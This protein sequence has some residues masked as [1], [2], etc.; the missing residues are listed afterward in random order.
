MD[1]D[2][3]PDYLRDNW[4]SSASPWRS[5][6]PAR[7][8]A[9]A[10]SRRTVASS[11]SLTPLGDA[12]MYQMPLHY[13]YTLIPPAHGGPPPNTAVYDN[14]W[15]LVLTAVLPVRPPPPHAPDVQRRDHENPNAC[16]VI[17][18]VSYHGRHAIE[19]AEEEEQWELVCCASRPRHS[20][21]CSLRRVECSS[22]RRAAATNEKQP[23]ELLCV[24]PPISNVSPL[25]PAVELS[26]LASGSTSP[27]GSRPWVLLRDV[28][29]VS[30]FGN[31]TL[32]QV[33]NCR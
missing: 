12:G 4:T 6:R 26:A 22:S 10:L 16:S 21:A 3:L 11:E 19:E 5:S 15:T 9:T 13:G 27:Y 33:T 28:L 14:A 29:L 7:R 25:T 30:D 1:A 31:N 2:A 32:Q 8:T 20:F 17:L 23:R 18:P 24:V